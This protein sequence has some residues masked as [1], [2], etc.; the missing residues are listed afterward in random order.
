MT[1]RLSVRPGWRSLWSSSRAKHTPE[2]SLSRSSQ[3]LRHQSQETVLACICVY[4]SLPFMS[5]HTFQRRFVLISE[6]FR[7]RSDTNR[8][9]PPTDTHL[10]CSSHI[11]KADGRVCVVTDMALTD[12]YSR[13]VGRVGMNNI[14]ECEEDEQLT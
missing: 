13:W 14:S 10:L 11:P 12:F 8:S 5:C 7:Q 6:L 2:F 1:S 3:L 9:R 4:I